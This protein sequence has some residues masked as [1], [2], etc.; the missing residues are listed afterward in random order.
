MPAGSVLGGWLGGVLG[1]RSALLVVTAAL[2]LLL[3]PI[4]SLRNLAEGPHL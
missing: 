1:L 3:S 4:R 2:P